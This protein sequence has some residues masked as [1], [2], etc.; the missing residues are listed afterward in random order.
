MGV[1][2]PT[3]SVVPRMYTLVWLYKKGCKASDC[4]GG[5]AWGICP[6]E[7]FDIY[8][9]RDHFLW[10]PRLSLQILQDIFSAAEVCCEALSGFIA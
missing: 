1:A 2:V 3:G 9:L 10:L 8:M 6:Q 5:G 4:R 7:N